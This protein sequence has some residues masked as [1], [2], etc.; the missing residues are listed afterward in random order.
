[1]ITLGQLHFVTFFIDLFLVYLVLSRNPRA[2]INQACAAALGC[3]ALWSLSYGWRFLAV[4]PEQAF[5]WMNIGAIGW[6]GV[7]VASLWFYIHL[8]RLEKRFHNL[9]SRILPCIPAVFFLAMQWSGNLISD[10]SMTPYGWLGNWS[11][12]LFSYLYYA[13]FVSFF[14]TVLWLVIYLWRQARTHRERSQAHILLVTSVATILIV[15]LTDLV[16]PLLKV[17]GIP[18]LA[19]IAILAM[20]IGLV[21]AITRFGLMGLNPVAAS[22][23]ILRTMTDSLVLP[24]ASGRIVFANQATAALTGLKPSELTGRYF[25]S[26]TDDPASTRILLERALKEGHDTHADLVYHDQAGIRLPVLLS[27]SAVRDRSGMVLGLLVISRDVSEI[28]QAEAELVRYRDLIDQVLNTLPEA[29][30]VLDPGMHIL[31]CNKTARTLMPEMQGDIIGKPLMQLFSSS[32]MSAEV[33]KLA[34]GLKSE[35]SLEFRDKRGGRE[36]QYVSCLIPMGEGQILTILRDITRER[37]QQDQLYMADRLSSVGE[38]AAGV[39]HE[40]NNPLTCVIGLADTLQTDK[41]PADMKEDIGIISHEAQRAARIIRSLLEFA[42]PQPAARRPVQVN[43]II[44][45]V[46]NLRGF[47]HKAQ[48]IEVLTELDPDLPEVQADYSQLQ[49]VFLNVL[50]NAEQAL[51]QVKTSRRLVIATRR[52]TTHLRVSFTDNGPGIL[53]EDLPRIFNPFY[54]T[55]ETGKGT[56]LGLSISYGIISNHGGRIWAESIPGQGAVF[57]IELPLTGAGSELV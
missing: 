7:P 41:L 8:A 33:G 26:L 16:L 34:G 20:D 6:C 31:F 28:R 5:R 30:L 18:P 39:A 24:D 43:R 23:D 55:K 22:E 4:T 15:L 42:R 11:S 45:E 38:M 2:R 50:L 56:G 48:E 53:S 54:T 1:M 47:E 21:L 49:Q 27:I 46:V 52:D 32:D 36:R 3:C 10:V 44:R 9:A 14:G 25:P 19:D 13:Y 12:S 17:P 57:H 40:V 29:V 51:S 35:I 37:E